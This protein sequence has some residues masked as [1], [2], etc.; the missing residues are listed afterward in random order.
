M[1]PAK[2]SSQVKFTSIAI[3]SNLKLKRKSLS[4]SSD[5]FATPAIAIFKAPYI[6]EHDTFIS[7]LPQPLMIE[8]GNCHDSLEDLYILQ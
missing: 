1:V 7:V 5:V 6:H 3:L 4:F 2:A 8:G